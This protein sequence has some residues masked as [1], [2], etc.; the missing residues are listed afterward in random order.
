MLI[1]EPI[2]RCCD[3]CQIHTQDFVELSS[4]RC[5]GQRERVESSRTKQVVNQIRRLQST[6]E[7]CTLYYPFAFGLTTLL[8]TMVV[9][10][11]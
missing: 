7:L 1:M 2:P 8:S 3:K 5:L 6:P 11:P 9:P 10:T 4:H